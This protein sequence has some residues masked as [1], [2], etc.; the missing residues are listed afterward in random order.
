MIGRSEDFYLGLD[1]TRVKDPRDAHRQQ[2][3]VDELLARMYADE[4]AKRREIQILADE[5]GMGKTFVALGVAY[6]VLR[7]I[8]Q[9]LPSDDLRG[10]YRKILVITPQNHA[11]FR[12]WQREVAEFVRRCVHPEHRDDAQKW[13]AAAPVTRLDDLPAQ[14]QRTGKGPDVLIMSTSVFGGGKFLHYDLKRRFLLGVLFRHWGNRFRKDRRHRLLKGAPAG[15]PAHQDELTDLHAHERESLPFENEQDLLDVLR[16]LEREEDQALERLLELCLDLSALYTR[17]RSEKFKTIESQLNVLYRKCIERMVAKAFPL[18]IVDEAH[19]WKNGP[20]AGTNGYRDFARIIARNTRRLLLL[21]A[22]PFQLRPEEILEILRISDDIAPAA[23]A[24]QTEERRQELKKRREAFIRPVLKNSDRASRAFSKAWSKLPAKGATTDAIEAAWSS[25]PLAEA[26]DRLRHIAEQDGVVKDGHVR[27][28]ATK[29]TEQLDPNVRLLMRQALDLYT[30]NA[31]LS[32]ELGELV[33]R[34][35]RHTDHR[36]FRVGREYEI[37]WQRGIMRPDSHILH[38]AVGIDVRGPAE[39]PHYLLMRCV[40]EMKNGKGRSSLGTNLTGCYSTL[41]ASAEGKDIE[42]LLAGSERGALYFKLLLDMVTEENDPQHPKVAALV[43][44]TLDNWRSGEKTLIFCFRTNTARRLRDIVDARIRKELDKRRNKCLGGDKALKALR[45]RLTGRER[46]L[47]SIGLDRVLWSFYRATEGTPDAALFS[48]ADLHLSDAD[49]RV[50]ARLALSFGVD[51]SDA[52][53]DRVFL[54]RATEHVIANRLRRDA[55]P[56]VWRD[57]LQEMADEAWLR[58]PYGLTAHVGDDDVEGESTDFDERGAHTRYEEQEAPSEARVDA[59]AREIISRRDTATRRKQISV[60]DV[61]EM[62]PSLWFGTCP[63]NVQE[64]AKGILRRMHQF[65]Q[66]LTHVNKSFD[67]LARLKTFEALRRALLRESVL[68]R[69]LPEECD[70]EESGWG[71]LLEEAFYAP[72]PNQQ[73]SMADRIAV[74]LEDLQAASGD[75]GDASSQRGSLYAST[76]LRDQQF[77]ALVDGSTKPEVRE[78]IF[79]GF[80]TPLLPEVLIC[81]SVGQEGI[82]L[83][84][85]CRHVVHYDLAWNPAVLEQRTGR[86]D[87]I[88]SKTFRERA[89]GADGAQT[90]LE[91]GVPFLAGTYDE[92]MYEELRI[93]AQTFEVLTGGDL[94]AENPEGADN[95]NGDNHAL[96]D[97]S[98]AV[99]PQ[100]MVEALRVHL[101]VWREET[102]HALEDCCLGIS[103]P[104]L[105]T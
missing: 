90:A 70:R 50:L 4:P 12:K 69:L 45:G 40:T 20:S 28:L 14:L 42:K 102:P 29:A 95:A 96:D 65:I 60:F 73:E 58:L 33:V 97:L 6:S 91:I 80:N 37:N 84:R 39:L 85:H 63:T 83:H 105:S 11:L 13:F 36:L 53:V 75:L 43:E 71:D 2:Q 94:A 87:R 46:D 66:H 17:N 47:I 67:W 74:F 64:A 103:A 52:R 100:R 76:R 22:T 68:L 3:T 41:M 21:T 92:R 101:E 48:P 32:Q 62:G 82:D 55:M 19:N 8:Q 77:V 24:D 79:A 51:L 15:W 44:Q 98:F 57:L 72:L 35:R 25:Q 93:R 9:K 104:D 23:K 27:E 16:G 34:H 10:C 81:T 7:Q 26:R 88:G 78:R 61:Y 31:D 30:Y 86:A 1:T 18:V 49:L 89:L 56:P 59:L 99:L 38:G 5:V 54:N